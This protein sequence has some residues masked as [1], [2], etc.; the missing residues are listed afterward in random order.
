VS[1]RRPI[2]SAA[3]LLVIGV[4]LGLAHNQAG[5]MSRPPRGIPWFASKESPLPSGFAEGPSPS[6]ST[7]LAPSR[8]D[9]ARRPPPTASAVPAHRPERSS[10]PSRAIA[11][12]IPAPTGAP[13]VAA[14]PQIADADHPVPVEMAAARRL[15]DA[16]AALFLDARDPSE[17]ASGHIPGALRLTRDDVLADPARARALPVRGRPI[18][19]YCEGGE[20][21]A[22]LDL[23]RALV[24]AGFRKVL[25]YGGGFPE[26]SAAGQPVE[27]GSGR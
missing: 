13:G 16:D 4:A 12:P 6:D 8:V 1:G 5:L 21:E 23:A 22:S 17:Y 14:P 3:L 11:S 18:I 20:C 26:W 15:L 9:S 2:A 19:T 24:D 7:L 25:V 10:K 27:R